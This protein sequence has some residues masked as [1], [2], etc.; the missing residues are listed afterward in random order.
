MRWCIFSVSDTGNSEKRNQCSPNR[1][2]GQLCLFGFSLDNVAGYRSP[3]GTKAIQVFSCDKH[4][5]YCY[6]TRIAFNFAFAEYFFVGNVKTEKA[7]G[8]FSF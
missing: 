2:K 5:S 1:I 8:F 6:R 4:P 7:F 3:V